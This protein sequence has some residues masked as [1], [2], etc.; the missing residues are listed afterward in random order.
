MSLRGVVLAGLIL[1][2][3]AVAGQS[4]AQ[5][6]GRASCGAST[7]HGGVVDRGAPWRH[8]MTKWMAEDPHVGA[9]LLLM[10]SDSQRI[11]AQLDHRLPCPP[12]AR[13]LQVPRSAT[14]TLPE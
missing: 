4:D 5:M 12:R 2:T 7:C 14:A 11:A 8:A 1:V 9:G 3:A 10:D 13:R 6:L